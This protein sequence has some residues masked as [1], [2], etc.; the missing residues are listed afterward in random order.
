[1]N[2][3]LATCKLAHPVLEGTVWQSKQQTAKSKK[4]RKGARLWKSVKSLSNGDF[5]KTRR[6]LTK[7]KSGVPMGWVKISM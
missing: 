7:G 3:P 4:K 2:L 1:M 5:P 6:L